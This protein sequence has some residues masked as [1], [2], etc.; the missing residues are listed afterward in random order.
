M[1][2]G[3]DHAS[4]DDDALEARVRAA[5]DELAAATGATYEIVA[6]DPGLADTAAFC[7]AYGYR[8]EES[9]N[10]ILVAGKADPPAYV[11]CI[12]LAT[13]RLD[14]NRTV[15]H[16]LGVRKASFAR[17]EDTK[18]VTGMVLGG[19][20]PFALP[21]DLP[22]WIDARVMACERVVTGAGSRRAKI[23]GPPELLAARPGSEVVDGLAIEWDPTDSKPAHSS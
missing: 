11:V 1:S 9:A 21:P 22:V 19:V 10:A 8:L 6:C 20:T 13:T 7:D 14:V 2:D 5:L 12:V 16:R 4:D 3:T 17:P 23:V 18:A 15:R